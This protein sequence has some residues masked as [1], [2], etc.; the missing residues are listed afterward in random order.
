MQVLDLSDCALR[1]LP[2]SLSTLTALKSLDLSSNKLE[3]LPAALGR[4][5]ALQALALRDNP[6]APHLAALYAKV[7]AACVVVCL[8]F[9]CALYNVRQ[10]AAS[11][12]YRTTS[13]VWQTTECGHVLIA[14]VVYE[15]YGTQGD[16]RGPGEGEGAIIALLDPSVPILDLYWV[17]CQDFL[18]EWFAKL[19]RC[20][21]R[22]STLQPQ[23]CVRRV[24]REARARERGPSSHCLTPQSRSSTSPASA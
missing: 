11:S 22:H 20:Y 8:V 18:S 15:C 17:K 14:F 12:A 24:T 5:P 23:L 4:L 21:G 2:Q 13:H 3:T 9:S 16:A 1:V 10:A 7:R 19:Y 6:L